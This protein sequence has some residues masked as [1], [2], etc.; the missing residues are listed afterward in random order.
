[1]PPGIGA[2]PPPPPPPG[3]WAQQPGPPNTGIGIA[4]IGCPP[5][6]TNLS[7]VIAQ[8]TGVW[9]GT[10][11]P[12]SLPSTWVHSPAVLGQ[13]GHVCSWYSAGLDQV[14]GSCPIFPNGP[15]VLFT[16]SIHEWRARCWVPWV[17]SD[18]VAAELFFSAWAH[19]PDEFPPPSHSATWVYEPTLSTFLNCWLEPGATPALSVRVLTP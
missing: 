5:C 15:S 3:G 12:C 8:P 9:M 6:R 18:F 2:P 7:Q 14:G 10:D 17:M 16:C 11:Q 19:P 1:V 13:P 4:D